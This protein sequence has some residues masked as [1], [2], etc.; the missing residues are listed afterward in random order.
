MQ[1]LKRVHFWYC[2]PI[3]QGLPLSFIII[4]LLL[5]VRD[6]LQLIVSLNHA[7]RQTSS[8]GGSVSLSVGD[9]ESP[10]DPSITR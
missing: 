7:D 8:T 5:K 1:W 4:F 9:A 2:R 6:L 3:S 10:R